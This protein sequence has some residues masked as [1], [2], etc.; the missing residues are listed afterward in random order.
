LKILQVK[1]VTEETQFPG[2]C[3]SR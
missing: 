1:A 3:F 2:S